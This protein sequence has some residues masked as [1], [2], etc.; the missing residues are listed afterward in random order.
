MTAAENLFTAQQDTPIVY[1]TGEPAMVGAVAAVRSQNKADKVKLF[2][3]DLTAEVISGI[4]DG[5]VMGVVQ[6]DP[7]TEGYEAVK[8]CK[9]LAGGGTVDKFIDVPITIVTKDNVDQFR[10]IFQ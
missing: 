1:A 2:G 3:W 6:Q 5:F 4:D 8:A 9:T 7:K 10:S